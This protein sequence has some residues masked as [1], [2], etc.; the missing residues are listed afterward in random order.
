MY[1]TNT[2]FIS[3]F[4]IHS[5]FKLFSMFTNYMRPCHSKIIFLRTSLV[6]CLYTHIILKYFA[7]NTLNT[8][9]HVLNLNCYYTPNMN[10]TRYHSPS[11]TR[12]YEA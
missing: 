9:Y 2:R 11:A 5:Q 4:K 12:K 7:N 10:R 8:S 1:L 3:V 6:E